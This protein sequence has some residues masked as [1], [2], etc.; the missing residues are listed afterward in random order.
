ME[1][2]FPVSA[3]GEDNR[4]GFVDIPLA[5][6]ALAGGDVAAVG[7]P[8]MTHDFEMEAGRAA[9]V[10]FEGQSFFL[11]VPAAQ[12]PVDGQRPR[13]ELHGDV[14]VFEAAGREVQAGMKAGTVQPVRIKD[15]SFAG[16]S[17]LDP[18]QRFGSFAAVI[19]GKE[20]IPSPRDR[21]RADDVND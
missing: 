14:R 3:G 7:A 16:A 5:L 19:G 4:A 1:S 21:N 13:P 6:V 18:A 12:K 20:E 9:K 10:G 11:L 2:C 17:G 8:A 15:A